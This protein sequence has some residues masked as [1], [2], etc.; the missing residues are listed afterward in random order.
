[1]R[2]AVEQ[3]QPTFW[4]AS[5]PNQ[6]HEMDEATVPIEIAAALNRAGFATALH[7]RWG[8]TLP[9]SMSRSLDQILQQHQGGSL[10]IDGS[11]QLRLEQ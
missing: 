4:P 9:N 3:G 2:M 10:V 6:Y 5:L 7:T 1:M 11:G 8:V